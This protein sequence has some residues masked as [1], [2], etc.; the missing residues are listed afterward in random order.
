MWSTSKKLCIMS[1]ILVGLSGE[2]AAASSQ[3]DEIVQKEEIKLAIQKD[4]D[5]TR[6][7]VRRNLR[8]SPDDVFLRK[9]REDPGC[10][11]VLD[12]KGLKA[13]TKW[14]REKK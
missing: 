14:W 9:C 5:P 13:A 11:K 8:A 2:Y 1:L 4:E 12:E 6:V 7:H 3:K 10:R